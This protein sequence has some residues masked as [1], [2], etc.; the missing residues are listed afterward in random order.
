MGLV[1]DNL[2]GYDNSITKAAGKLHGSLLLAHGTSDDNVHL[3]NSIQMID[4]FIKEG[5]QFRLMLYP[6]KTHGIAGSAARSHLFHMM[7]D[8]W[9]K[10][11]K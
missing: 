3:Q 5:K 1:K 2:I 9:D 6:N 10:E 7:Q 4:A 11:L 8:H